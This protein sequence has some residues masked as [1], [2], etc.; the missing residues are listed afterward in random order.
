MRYRGED[1]ANPIRPRDRCDLSGDS[2]NI[3]V[4]ARGSLPAGGIVFRE[5]AGPQIFA[6][7][8]YHHLLQQE[9]RKHVRDHHQPVGEVRKIPHHRQRSE[10]PQQRK[11]H[12]NSLVQY[13]QPALRAQKADA[14][15]AVV[16]PAE[17]RGRGEGEDRER[18][19][20]FAAVGD[21]L[22]TRLRDD[23]AAVGD[24]DGAARG[25]HA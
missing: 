17:E 22:E 6:R 11:Q 25:D 21:L 16:E 14:L 10:R 8:G 7:F 24:V 12:V 4:K 1:C 23:V 19:Q 5:A 20:I 9:H 3:R 18:E 2:C 13:Q 15:L